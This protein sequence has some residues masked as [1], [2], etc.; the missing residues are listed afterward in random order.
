MSK[1]AVDRWKNTDVLFIDEISMLSCYTFDKL[2]RIGS[3]IREDDRPFGGIQV[4]LIIQGPI[5]IFYL[6]CMR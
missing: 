6:T 3:F 4:S 2:S 5:S 1:D